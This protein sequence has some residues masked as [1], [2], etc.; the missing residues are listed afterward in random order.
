MQLAR[1]KSQTL[2]VIHGQKAQAKLM[3]DTLEACDLS[4]HILSISDRD[5]VSS[6]HFQAA[7]NESLSPDLVLLDHP[8]P[9][10]QGLELLKLVRKHPNTQ[11]SPTVIISDIACDKDVELS[12]RFGLNS[13]IQAPKQ[14]QDFIAVTKQLASYWLKWNQLPQQ[15][16]RR[17]K[18]E[19]EN[20]VK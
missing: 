18:K 14:R 17:Y 12:Y 19:F 10:K 20:Y 4:G 1:H 7:P 3:V 11:I 5:F 9:L 2:L 15:F 6:R 8:F 16:S 13:F